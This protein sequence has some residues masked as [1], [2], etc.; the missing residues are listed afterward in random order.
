SCVND[1]R[2]HYIRQNVLEYN[3]SVF[4]TECSDCV[5]ILEF[6]R[7]QRRPADN[8][9]ELRQCSDCNSDGNV[10]CTSAENTHNRKGKQDARECKQD[11]HETH[12]DSIKPSAIITCK[13]TDR[14]SD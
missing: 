14:H 5:D 4:C 7:C 10:D 13:E 3:F 1:N 12:D 11:I 6:P 2:R 9:C 8:T